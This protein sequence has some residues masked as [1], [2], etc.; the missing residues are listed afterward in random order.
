[1]NIFLS[2]EYWAVFISA[3]TYLFTDRIQK[4]TKKIL[5]NPLLISTVITV[6][7][8]ILINVDYDGYYNKAKYLHYLLTPATVCLAIPLYEQLSLLKKNIKAIVIGICSGV[9]TSL[10][11]I[12]LF[13]MLFDFTHQ[14]YVTL[15]PKS[16]TAAMGM[17]ISEELGGISS[18]TV[19]IIIMTGITGNIIAEIVCK[20]FRI[21][22]SIA[23]G[24]AIGTASHAMGTAKALEMGETE[25][26]MSS[27]SI[28]VSGI[29]TV[30]FAGIY[31]KLY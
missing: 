20:L 18:L 4:K 29:V 9:L 25:G 2:T 22:D 21:R 7:F 11:S 12:L 13:S 10:T 27:L 31:S 1:M 28:A 16:V 3:A 15:L 8:L 26:A 23:K 17:G 6:L 30:L 14:M 24:I 19:P 5:F